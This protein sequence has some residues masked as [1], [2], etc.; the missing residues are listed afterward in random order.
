MYNFEGTDSIY[1]DK[2]KEYFQ[3][4]ISSYS[5]GNY[6]S[7]NV[8]LYSVVICD[9]LY[10]LQ[11]IRDLYD[12]S[13]AKQILEEVEHI[14]TDNSSKSKS[15]WEKELID[16]ISAGTK[17]LEPEDIVNINHLFDNR[18]FSAHPALNENF[19][20]ISPS[21]ETTAANIKNALKIFVRPPYFV[22][23]VT[24]YLLDDLSK[25]EEVY[26]NDYEGL[27]S[28]LEKK[29]YGRMPLTMKLS[30]VKALWKLS[31]IVIND[32]CDNNRAINV[33]GLIILI[34]SI[35]TETE[36]FI[37][38]NP[39]YFTV[40]QND[41]AKGF[42]MQLL[43]QCP[44]LY[45]VLGDETKKMLQLFVKKQP[46]YMLVSWCIYPTFDEH[47]EALRAYDSIPV[48]KGIVEQ[49][50]KHYNNIGRGYEL[51]D[52]F[53]ELYGRSPRFDYADVYFDYCIE[54]FISKMKYSQFVDLIKKT[55][56]N[57]QIHGRR[58]AYYAN[59]QI[60]R[61]AIS[62][63]GKDFDYSAYSHFSFNKALIDEEDD[64]DNTIADDSSG[65]EET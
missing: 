30:T 20:L 5:V 27:K 48:T 58:Y 37:K 16:K 15:I 31:F 43:G 59:N 65:N 17:I 25:Y 28:F 52:F 63:L 47:I 4:V 57:Y 50:Y 40:A 6:R 21:K 7:A 32:E 60:M 46:K 62:V 11:E 42:L 64:D 56:A 29:Y 54:P 3:E 12:D 51:L 8:M 35:I 22:T 44:E 61:V 39:S 14:R 1:F 18:N 26:R 34:K 13:I 9:L 2:T 23:K 53:I 38:E 45:C 55:N 19:E 24:E 10:K 49:M 36:R 33:V 41:T